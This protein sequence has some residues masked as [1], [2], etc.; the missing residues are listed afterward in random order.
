MNLAPHIEMTATR[1]FLS[2]GMRG[3]FQTLDIMRQIIDQYKTNTDIR[4]ASIGLIF[5]TPEKDD[6]AEATVIFNFVRDRVR[7]V[8]DIVDVE[9]ISTPDKTLMSMIGDCDDQTILL[10]TMLES[11]GLKSRLVA[12]GYVSN[13]SVEH[14]YLQVYIAGEWVNADP[15]EHHPLGWAPPDPACVYV[16][17]VQ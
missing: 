11:V 12:A 14:V 7:Y 2:N 4:Q 9:T 10:G 16:E 6:N 15:T 13:N 17:R 8:R 3:I 5:L 1:A